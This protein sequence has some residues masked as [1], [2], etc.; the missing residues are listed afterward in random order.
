M[1]LNQF[2]NVDVVLDKA[3]DNII[4]KQFVSAGDKDGRS[5][6]AQLTD[7][8]VIGEIIGAA[9]NLYWHNQASGLTDLSA[10]YV[11]D[12]ATSVFK[13][14]YPQN[15]LTP[16]K[17]IAYIQILHGGK[18][19]HTKPFEITVQNL[20]GT[21]RGVLATAEYS[22]LVTTLAKA[23]EFETEIAKK[24]DKTQVDVFGSEIDVAR[25][26]AQTLGERL[27][28]EKSEVDAQLAQKANEADVYLKSI[29]I[30]IND[31]DEPTRQAFL[32]AQGIDVNYVL[33]N[34]NVHPINTSFFK[35]GKNL[36]NPDKVSNGFNLSHSNGTIIVNAAYAV[37]DYIIVAPLTKYVF[38]RGYRIAFF[39]AA[40]V[41]ISGLD[42][43][44]ALDYVVETPAT[45][46]YIRFDM[47]VAD[48]NAQ[49]LELGTS[50]TPFEP[51]YFYFD[52]DK[53]LKNISG[54]MLKDKS[55]ATDKTT[56]ITAGKNK[57]DASSVSES[58]YVSN[59]DGRLLPNANYDTSDYISVFAET[60]YATNHNYFTA[61]YNSA[62]VFISGLANGH[63]SVFTTP[64][65]TAYAKVSIPKN[66]KAEFQFEIGE[67]VTNY[68]PYQKVLKGV[69]LSAS[70]LSDDVLVYLP[71]NICIAVGRT[72]EIYNRQVVFTGNIDN[73][74]IAWES[75]IG[76][77]YGRKW[78]FKGV[79]DKVGSHDLTLHVYDNNMRLLKSVKTIVK[80]VDAV[81]DG[82]LNLLTIGDSLTNWKPWLQ[83]LR[84]LS[85]DKIK[86][87]GTRW[88]GDIQG[89]NL[90]HEG[91]SGATAA[92]YL[93]N[94]TYDFETN[95][96]TASNPFWNPATS[97][98]DYAYYKSTYNIN[99]DAIQVFLGTNGIALDPT[100]NA[101]NI[102]AIVDGIRQSDASIPIFVVQTLYRGS[103]D[104][105]AQ[106]L[107]TDG[108]SAANN[109][110][111]LNEDRKVFNLMVALDDIFKD[112]TNV[113]LVPIAATHDSEYNYRNIDDV[114]FANPR[115]Q[116]TVPTDS[117]ATH[118]KNSGYF[119]FADV[120]YS[121]LCKV[122]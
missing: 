25:D 87:V 10:F 29:G 4:Q 8:G 27:D 58:M 20:A 63:P 34:A 111:K 95:G 69:T 53:Y 54:G 98:F 116:I 37:S 86:H 46:K 68:E 101:N 52:S 33:G 31:F 74:H 121:A 114:M 65:D 9:L 49:Q 32:E 23:N 119:Q 113:H 108:Y 43:A 64:V 16:G 21:T 122:F 92:W 39:N 61:F 5:L 11:V 110:F 117:E 70:E 45:T 76:K 106:Q 13:I 90:N 6:T 107:S 7:N 2:R 59:V 51:F 24:A 100:I 96:V 85:G 56:F 19:T 50:S 82:P 115:S 44:W 26:G 75:T 30:N 14:D 60:S 102:K 103:Q 57:F 1:E 55:I 79:S 36:F 3:N 62:K 105:M 84:T 48:I 28:S 18:V 77:S 81:I 97:K 80:V 22:A 112:Y 15:M 91:R 67:S 41:F 47:P 118:P 17:V 104:G 12:R 66:L 83:E 94:S 40:N 71:E 99:P 42:G 89:G 38:K 88:N 93:A 78:S 120:M 73:V 72:I 109:V 35:T